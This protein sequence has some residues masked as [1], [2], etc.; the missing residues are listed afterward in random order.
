MPYDDKGDWSP[1]P[2]DLVYTDPDSEK[3]MSSKGHD[4]RFGVEF[5]GGWVPDPP[6]IAGLKKSGRWAWTPP[7]QR[8][9]LEESLMQ[10]GGEYRRRLRGILEEHDRIFER[11]Q[12]PGYKRN[13]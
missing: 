11:I 6:R 5:A 1:D 9:W 3:Y 8:K 13:S 12:P 4:T 10:P 7:V 2:E